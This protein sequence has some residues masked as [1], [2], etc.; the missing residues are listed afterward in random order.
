MSSDYSARYAAFVAGLRDVE[1][2]ERDRVANQA[3][4]L[5]K[6][7]VEN[8]RVVNGVYQPGTSAGYGAGGGG[9]V[10]HGVGHGVGQGVGH[11]IDV[12]RRLPAR[13]TQPGHWR[14][15]EKP[16]AH[17]GYRVRRDGFDR[18]VNPGLAFR[19]DRDVNP[20][21]KSLTSNEPPVGAGRR[22]QRWGRGD[23]RIGTSENKG[24]DTAFGARNLWDRTRRAREA[25][26]TEARVS[27]LA[28]LRGAPRAVPTPGEES[29]VVRYGR[30]A[31][32]DVY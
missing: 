6:R 7:D 28:G 1:T 2:R 3:N 30:R 24:G 15:D 11:G 29:R 31:T 17:N 10:G 9:G 18:D 20:G 23:D 14:S 22:Q 21:A 13:G 25:K 12:S 16:A 26:E 27:E 5:L 19:V 32:R 4:D 8:L